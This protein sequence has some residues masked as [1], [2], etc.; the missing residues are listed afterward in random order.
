MKFIIVTG[1]SGSGKTVTLKLLEDY[2]YYCADNLPVELIGKFVELLESSS[3]GNIGAAIGIDI[4]SSKKLDNINTVFGELDAK[5]IDYK[6]LYLDAD[7]KSLIKRYKET[8][9]SHP[10]ARNDRIETG[11]EKERV[12]LEFLRKRADYIIDTSRFLSKELKAELVR[13]FIEDKSYTKLFINIIS[14]GFMYGIPSDADLVFDV[15]FLPNP[16]YEEELRLKTGEDEKVKGYVFSE[17]SAYIFLT[18]LKDIIAFLLPL[19][20]KEGKSQ[21]VIAIGCTGGQHRSV[22]VAASLAE[23]VSSIEDLGGKLEHRDIYRNISR[24]S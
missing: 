5:H 18:K 12:E 4:R 19:Y 11:I 20:I 16:F 1:M 9:R 14:F 7:T 10:L 13:V 2:G 8:R 24:L 17:G 6:V 15:R 21:L 3:I 23:Y 22:A